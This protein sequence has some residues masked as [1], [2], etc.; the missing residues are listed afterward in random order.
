[1]EFFREFFAKL[2]SSSLDTKQNRRMGGAP[3]GTVHRGR[4]CSRAQGAQG[5]GENEEGGEGVIQSRLPRLENDSGNSSA[6]LM[7]GRWQFKVTA[8][9]RRPAAG[10]RRKRVEL[11]QLGI[12]ELV[13][14]SAAPVGLQGRRIEDGRRRSCSPWRRT[15][16]AR[17]AQQ[18]EAR[19]YGGW[20]AQAARAL[21]KRRHGVGVRGAHAPGGGAVQVSWPGT[22]WPWRRARMGFGGPGCRAGADRVGLANA[23]WSGLRC[24]IVQGAF[25]DFT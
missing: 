8:V 9:L 13:V 6:W 11:R 24:R 14:G 25:P 15:A 23:G 16:S 1:M 3:G 18:G 4:R 7:V 12:L 21:L 19:G 17:G 5:R 20:S 2:S 10:G 22:P